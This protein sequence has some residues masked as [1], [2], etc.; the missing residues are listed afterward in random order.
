M[1]SVRSTR[2]W[3]LTMAAFLLFAPMAS[4]GERESSSLNYARSGLYL[5]LG[6]VGGVYTQ[7]DS[8]TEKELAAIGYVIDVESSVAAGLDL[9]A[10]YRLHPHAAAQVHFQ[11]FPNTDVEFDGVKVIEADTWT[12]TGDIKG[13]VFTKRFQPYVLAGLGIMHTK[14]KDT[15]GLGFTESTEEFAVRLGGGIDYY[16]TENFV[17]EVELGG[18]LPSGDLKDLDLFTFAVGLQY[19]F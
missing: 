19:R 15:L 9:Q 6:F 4:A 12:L 5:G 16:L 10:G 7:A 18:V 3:L 17:F 14:Q 11:Y 8:E 1:T 2:P 13:Y